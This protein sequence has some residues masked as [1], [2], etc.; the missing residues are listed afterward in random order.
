[1][2]VLLGAVLERKLFVSSEARQARAPH[3]KWAIQEID[4]TN[5]GSA[6]AQAIKSGNAITVTDGS[7]KNGR[8]TAAFILE[9]SDNFEPIGCIVGVNSISGEKEDQSSYRS[10]IGGVSGVIETVGILCERFAIKSGAIKVGLDGDQAMQNIFGKW[11]L[12]P[13][14]ADYDLLKDLRKKIQKSPIKWTGIWVEGHLDNHIQFE[15]L[16]RWSQLNVECDGPAKDYWNSCTESEAW[17]PNKGFADEG[18]S[19]WIEGKKV[20]KVDKKI[21]VRLHVFSKHTKNYWAKKHHLTSDLIVGIHQL[22][23]NPV[24]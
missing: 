6:M 16:D 1:L 22:Y 14:Q 10:E 15:D 24:A 4:I 11:P 3:D 19:V 5:D 17:M 21:S 23:E 20:T 7:Y 12:Y 2:R 18:W 9:I 8:G 13:R